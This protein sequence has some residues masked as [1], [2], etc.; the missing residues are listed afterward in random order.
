MLPTT[1]GPVGGPGGEA[2]ARTPFAR[3]ACGSS[4]APE[5]LP[6]CG[7]GTPRHRN[8]SFRRPGDRAEQTAASTVATS[9]RG[10][11]EGIDEYDDF[12][13]GGVTARTGHPR[14]VHPGDPRPS[15]LPGRPRGRGPRPRGA[16]GA[17]PAG[18]DDAGRALGAPG[19]RG[20]FGALVRRGR[21]RGAVRPDAARCARCAGGGLRGDGVPAHILVGRGAAAPR[22]AGLALGDGAR[23]R[24]VG[25]VRG[26]GSARPRRLRGAR[27]RA[28]AAGRGAGPD[29]GTAAA[30]AQRTGAG[31][32][33]ER[34]GAVRDGP[35]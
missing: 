31:V 9:R 7:E 11:L 20:G 4:G 5:H 1:R 14:R 17:T 13:D 30:L 23:P 27:A 10:G 34:A 6:S 2:G 25:G 3:W 21:A 32:R 29:P 15:A 16:R 35:W 24:A 26:S 28:R 33:R 12:P 22:R 8:S 19:P 18:A